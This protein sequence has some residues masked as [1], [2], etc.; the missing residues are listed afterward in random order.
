MLPTDGEAGPDKAFGEGD[1]GIGWL[2]L[3]GGQS[4][5]RLLSLFVLNSERILRVRCCVKQGRR[6]GVVVVPLQVVSSGR[7]PR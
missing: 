6:A 5:G 2:P 3:S 7:R 4:M 1:Q